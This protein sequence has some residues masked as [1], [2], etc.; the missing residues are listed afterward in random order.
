MALETKDAQKVKSSWYLSKDL[1]LAMRLV[2]EREHISASGQIEIGVRE[3]LKRHKE[4]LE[5]QGINLWG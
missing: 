1:L 5:E 2:N 3:Y 4:I